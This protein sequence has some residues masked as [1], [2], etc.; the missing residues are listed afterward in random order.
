MIPQYVCAS[1][2]LKYDWEVWPETDL[3]PVTHVWLWKGDVGRLCTQ[4]GV[5]GNRRA[6][7]QRLLCI[8]GELH[9]A[10]RA[11][12]LR[13]HHHAR[14]P[15]QEAVRRAREP[16]AREKW[17][18]LKWWCMSVLG[19]QIS[20][21]Q[22]VCVW[23]S[24]SGWTWTR[25]DQFPPDDQLFLPLAGLRQQGFYPFRATTSNSETLL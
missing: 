18:Y 22:K 21:W 10:G 25:W 16:G 4:G 23:F 24:L 2:Y 9:Q 13:H 15:G 1:T 19:I 6:F 11:V 5:G 17:R 7:D 12:P 8:S 14:W 20:S 3:L